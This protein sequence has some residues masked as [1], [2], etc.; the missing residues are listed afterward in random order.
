MPISESFTESKLIAINNT[1]DSRYLDFD[2]LELSDRLSRRENWSLFKHR[3][4]TSGNKL[5][6]I[7]GEI[8][9][10][11]QFLPFPTILSIY[12]SNCE[13]CMCDANFPQLRKSDMS[14]YGYLEVFRRIPSTSR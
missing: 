1:V 3:N 6:W 7:R 5:L 8:A 14:K 2:Y 13:I 12:I 9:P 10:Q 11:E 4:L